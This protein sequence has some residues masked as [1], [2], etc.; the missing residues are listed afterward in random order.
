MRDRAEIYGN[1][2]GPL[3][4]PDPMTEDTGMTTTTYTRH[5]RG[6]DQDLPTTKFPTYRTA[7]GEYHR[8][9]DLCRA[10]KKNGATDV[11]AKVAQT[12]AYAE[13]KGLT[14]EHRVKT[15]DQLSSM[16]FRFDHLK[17]SDTTAPEG[18]M[19]DL[20]N[21]FGAIRVSFMTVT[22]NGR[23]AT[24][25]GKHAEQ[26]RMTTK[27]VKIRTYRDLRIAIDVMGYGVRT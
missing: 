24:S 19:L 26:G 1:L 27:P 7:A 17:I 6:C 4:F 11:P 8:N 10:C 14:V 21:S 12:I 5:C 15:D 23:K 18:T 25:L 20:Y 3:V 2:P 9:Y 16:Q 22:R 13:A